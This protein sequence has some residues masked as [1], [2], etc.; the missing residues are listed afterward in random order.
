MVRVRQFGRG[1]AFAIAAFYPAISAAQTQIDDEA[2]SVTAGC[3]DAIK[4]AGQLQS[5]DAGLCL[6]IIKARHLESF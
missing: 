1:V 4:S 3:H 2:R 6:G 5:F